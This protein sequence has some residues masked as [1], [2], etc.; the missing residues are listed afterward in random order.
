M[1]RVFSLE[2]GRRAAVARFANLR[3][4]FDI[5][6]EGDAELLRRLFRAAAREDVDF[7][8]AVRTNEV[9]HVFDHADDVHLHL[10]EH[11]DGLARILQRDVGWGRDHDSASQ[12]DSLN[13]RERNVASSRRKVNDKII[14]LSP[15]HRS[16]EL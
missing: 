15:L 2:Y 1:G 10:A 14:K 5:S 13:Q 8:L 7:M 6:E 11:L 3:I 16:Q 4:E 12:W 9:T